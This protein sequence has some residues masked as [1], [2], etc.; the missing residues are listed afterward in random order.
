M[1]ADPRPGLAFDRHAAA[2]G[3][4]D[5]F[6]EAEAEAKAA[7]GAADVPAKQPIP[8]PRQLVGRNA[9]TGV[10]NR[11]NGAAPSRPISTSTRPPAACI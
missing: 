5:R 2:V 3:F 9:R 10:A 1:N 7:L 8:D 6:D 4:D 11:E